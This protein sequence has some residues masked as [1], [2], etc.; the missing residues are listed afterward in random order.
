MTAIQ[1][2]SQSA[3]AGVGRYHVEPRIGPIS[4]CWLLVGVL[5][6]ITLEFRW[7]CYIVAKRQVIVRKYAS[8]NCTDW[9]L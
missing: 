5:Y 9:L 8:L 3:G 4:V 7:V 6:S 2:G 1:Q